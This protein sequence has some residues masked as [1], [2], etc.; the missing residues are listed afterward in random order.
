MVWYCPASVNVGPDKILTVLICL[1]LSFNTSYYQSLVAGVQMSEL[2]LK[3]QPSQWSAFVIVRFF[4]HGCPLPSLNVCPFGLCSAI[5][6]V[7][8]QSQSFPEESC[9]GRVAIKVLNVS[10]ENSQRG[11]VFRTCHPQLSAPIYS[12]PKPLIWVL[13]IFS[14]FFYLGKTK[15]L[16]RNKQ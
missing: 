12:L 15:H 13:E 4:T 10:R 11:H 6:S 7:V 16:L 3:I 5:S 9:E 14:T 2:H 8:S 1:S